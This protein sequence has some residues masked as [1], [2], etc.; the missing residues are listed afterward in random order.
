LLACWRSHPLGNSLVSVLGA[1]A[2]HVQA[3]A[4]AIHD[5]LQENNCQKLWWDM[6]SEVIYHSRKCLNYKNV[7]D[8]FRKYQRMHQ[9]WDHL[10]FCWEDSL[11]FFVVRV[12]HKKGPYTIT[13]PPKWFLRRIRQFRMKHCC[14]RPG[15]D[16]SW[17]QT[18][19]HWQGPGQWVAWKLIHC[20]DQ[21]L[22]ETFCIFVLQYLV[23][24]TSSKKNK[25]KMLK[26]IIKITYMKIHVIKREWDHPLIEFQ[27]WWNNLFKYIIRGQ[28]HE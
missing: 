18:K 4:E 23:V 28:W 6:N 12:Y 24:K 3:E 15:F 8:V 7:I 10:R 26:Y 1:E 27:W 17:S 2:I 9:F 21:E 25:T 14:S 13:I 11:S 20:W 19:D 5:H 22:I 16:K